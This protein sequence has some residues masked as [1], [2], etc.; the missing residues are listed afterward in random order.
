MKPL[1]LTSSDTSESV[2][3]FAAHSETHPSQ[4]TTPKLLSLRI[5]TLP[6]NLSQKTTSTDSIH[7]ERRTSNVSN[8]S[9]F[10]IDMT[11]LLFKIS[12]IDEDITLADHSYTKVHKLCD[13]LQGDLWK[14]Q[15]MK[16]NEYVTIKRTD[17]QL[18]QQQIS[19]DD[20][21]MQFCVS[22]NI[23]KESNILKRL[24][25]DNH[26][27]GNYIIQYI[28]FFESDT[29][30]YLVMQYVESETN[31]KQFVQTAHKHIKN[32]K[33]KL[34]QYQ[35]IIKYLYWQLIVTVHWMHNDMK[36]A[37]LDVFTEN[38]MV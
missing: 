1:F 28:N 2:S 7:K 3:I 16:T 12:E 26:C 9:D 36:C 14:A 30:Y 35:K 5:D 8:C 32:N 37:H 34:K 29:D 4:Q 22:E 10:S 6:L 21:N 38:I 27:I 23:I 17:K 15:D 31:L 18:F 13:T 24:T 25:V 20:D 33:L 11:D 19:I